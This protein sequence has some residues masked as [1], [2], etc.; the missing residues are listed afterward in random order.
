MPP[1]IFDETLQEACAIANGNS[2]NQKTPVEIYREI[3]KNTAWN[4]L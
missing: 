2:K 3:I 4:N 1:R